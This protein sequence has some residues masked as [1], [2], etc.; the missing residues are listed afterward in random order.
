MISAHVPA[1]TN[2]ISAI[3]IAGRKKRKRFDKGRPETERTSNINESAQ[4]RGRTKNKR[5]GYVH[6]PTNPGRN[7]AA[8]EKIAPAESNNDRSLPAAGRNQTETRLASGAPSSVAGTW[9]AWRPIIPPSAIGPSSGVT[10][11]VAG[12][13]A[14]EHGRTGMLALGKATDLGPGPPISFDTV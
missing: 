7:S 2:A 14:G 4:V 8:R 9:L 13:D 1:L 3:A 6:A 12:T 11:M 10:Q 5:N